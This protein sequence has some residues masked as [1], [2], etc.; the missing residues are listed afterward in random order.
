M[1][2]K[3]TSFAARKFDFEKRGILRGGY[4]ADIVIFDEDKVMDRASWK[5]PHQYPVGIEYVLVNGG[6]VIEKGEHTGNLP[7]KV[8]RKKVKV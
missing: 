5:D 8:L 6:I 4:Y 3:I 2:K 7:G 1:I